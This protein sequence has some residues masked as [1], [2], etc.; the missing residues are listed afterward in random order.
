MEHNSIQLCLFSRVCSF[1]R[2]PSALLAVC[3]SLCGRSC[4]F[5]VCSNSFRCLATAGSITFLLPLQLQSLFPKHLSLDFYWY[6]TLN[7]P[8]IRFSPLHSTFQC[9][10]RSN[11]SGSTERIQKS[12]FFYCLLLQCFKL[13]V[14][15]SWSSAEAGPLHPEPFSKTGKQVTYF[16]PNTPR[17]SAVPQG[18][19]RPCF[20]AS[21]SIVEL[22][23]SNANFR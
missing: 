21:T 5:T 15:G 11:S 8:L 23:G 6:S 20:A 12:P 3:P 9:S 4:S 7:C 2:F 1:A 14:L 19:N 13:A 18:P 17:L 22:W 10:G 16:R